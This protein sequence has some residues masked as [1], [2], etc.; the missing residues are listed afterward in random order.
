[1]LG[2]FLPNDFGYAE[3]VALF[4]TMTTNEYIKNVKQ[5]IYTPFNKK[6]WQ[7]SFYE[8]VIRNEY[9]YEQVAEYIRNNPLKWEEDTEF[10]P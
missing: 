8:H 9:D 2:V 6:L 3:I 7:N 10:R 1:M 5:N 4:K